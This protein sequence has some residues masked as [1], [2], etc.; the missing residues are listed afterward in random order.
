MSADVSE[1][2]AREYKEMSR[3]EVLL[4]EKLETKAADM[5]E[6]QAKRLAKTMYL[7]GKTPL[8]ISETLGLNIHTVKHWIS[9]GSKNELP[10]KSIKDSEADTRVLQILE[11]K[12]ASLEDIYDLGINAVRR[13]LAHIELNDVVLDV[14]SI[15]KLITILDTVDKW[16]RQDLEE[17]EA[18]NLEIKLNETSE[19]HPFFKQAE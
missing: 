16:K 7:D 6:P 11:N 10:W 17:E 9:K 13:G 5:S 18:E 14:T 4:V 8:E 2:S 19:T 1:A 12:Q 15:Q 3:R